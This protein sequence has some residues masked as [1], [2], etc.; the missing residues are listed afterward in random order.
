MGSCL[1]VDATRPRSRKR[2]SSFTPAHP[3]SADNARSSSVSSTA[4]PPTTPPPVSSPSGSPPP[5]ASFA[6]SIFNKKQANGARGRSSSLSDG[7]DGI[8]LSPLPRGR[9]EEEEGDEAVEDDEVASPASTS[10]TVSLRPVGSVSDLL[11]PSQID[12]QFVNGGL[13]G[14]QQETVV[15][16]SVEEEGGDVGVEDDEHPDPEVVRPMKGKKKRRAKEKEAAI[17]AGSGE[18]ERDRAST[19]AHG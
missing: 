19:A 5:T 11:R 1:S 2:S 14:R 4:S 17:L 15:E 13:E 18:R 16:A 10:S 12:S 7:T 9:S 6:R 8:A 3:L